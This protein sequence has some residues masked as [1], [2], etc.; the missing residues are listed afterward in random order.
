MTKELFDTVSKILMV[1]M[2]FREMNKM[3]EISKLVQ[4]YADNYCF[5]ESE[6][7]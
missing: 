1:S 2:D 4:K 5:R 7:E 6:K 3:D